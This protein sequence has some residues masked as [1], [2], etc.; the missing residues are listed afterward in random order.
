MN[1]SPPIRRRRL[2]A[3]VL[4]VAVAVG[5]PGAARA[6]PAPDPLDQTIPGGGPVVPGPAELTRGHVDVAPRFVEGRW[7]LFAYD[8]STVPPTWRTLDDTVIRVG[9]AA[10]QTMPDDPAYSFVGAEPGQPV[11]VVPQVQAPEVVWLG[12]N[13]QEPEVM[14]RISRGVTLTLL[15]VQGPGDLV[16]FLQAGN[17]G[18]PDVLWRSRAPQRQ[19]LWVEVNTHTHANW[20]F[21]RPGV[22]LVQVEAAAEL[23]DGRK[24][25]ETRTLRFAVGD[26]ADAGE[27]RRAPF[28]G[29]VAAAPVRPE[30]P[31][32][33]GDAA[34]GGG[35]TVL[36]VLLGLAAA[37]LAGAVLVT[38]QRAARARRQAASREQGSSR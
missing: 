7:S 33:D 3:A 37:L 38:T 2:V 26:A 1:P 9:D 6:Q 15:G 25:S 30:P 13:T 27:A 22:Y 28:T 5:V 24:V 20:A 4:V 19:P 23:V 31:A 29:A 10:V 34:G 16:V 18:R 8:G 11:H 14:A 36:V 12:W 32:A 35:G 21:T 17:L